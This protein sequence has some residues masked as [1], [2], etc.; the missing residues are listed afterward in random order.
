MNDFAT[1]RSPMTWVYRPAAAPGELETRGNAFTHVR[2]VE[3]GHRL[4][5]DD[6]EH[7]IVARDRRDDVG[8]FSSGELPAT[9]RDTCL[10]WQ[11]AKC[12]FERPRQDER[13]RLFGH[14][15]F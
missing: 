8:A 6:S 12:A 13:L 11:T 15:E 9:S 14:F 10:L 4:G 3:D 5:G 1:G 7:T 2:D